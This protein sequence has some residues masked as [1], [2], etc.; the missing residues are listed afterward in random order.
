MIAK[1]PTK[2]LAGV[3]AF[4]AYPWSQT[5]PPALGGELHNP[6]ILSAYALPTKRGEVEQTNE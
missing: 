5:G 3:L 6:N 4:N 2:Q 1:A